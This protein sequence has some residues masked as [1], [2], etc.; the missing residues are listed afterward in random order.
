MPRRLP[1]VSS[2][3]NTRQIATRC[4]SRPGNAEVIASTP[5]EM[6]TATVRV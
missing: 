2:A 5:A 3:R 1:I 4:S 6:L